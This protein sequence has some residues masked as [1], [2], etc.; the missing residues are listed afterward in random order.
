MVLEGEMNTKP[1]KLAS[2]VLILLVL[3]LSVVSVEARTFRKAVQQSDSELGAQISGAQGLRAAEP[4][5]SNL[6]PNTDSQT[7]NCEPT[8]KR[9]RGKRVVTQNCA[10][11]TTNRELQTANSI[12]GL[13][14]FSS[15]QIPTISQ[16]QN[17]IAQ[18]IIVLNTND[19]AKTKEAVDL[20]RKNGGVVSIVYIPNT[21]VVLKLPSNVESTLV[22]KYGAQISKS[23][24]P[25]GAAPALVNALN[26]PIETS[27]KTTQIREIR[28]KVLIPTDANANILVPPG[29]SGFPPGDIFGFNGASLTSGYMVGDVFVSVILPE[30]DGTI[31]PNLENWN[32]TEET[33]VDQQVTNALNWWVAR[34]TERGVSY[35][36]TFWTFPAHTKVNTG[37][38]PT[39]RVLSEHGLWVN[40]VFDKMGV[41]AA[42]DHIIRARNYDNSLRN[43]QLTDWAFTLFIPDASSGTNVEGSYAWLGGPYNVNN[44]GKSVNDINQNYLGETIT[45]ET[46]HIFWALD[47][48]LGS[49][50]SCTNKGGILQIENQNYEGGCLSNVPSIMRSTL[51]EYLSGALDPYGAGQIGWRDADSD[52]V[53]DSIDISYNTWDI[54]TDNDQTINYWDINDDN[55]DLN[56]VNDACPLSAGWSSAQG[57]SP[58]NLSVV[59][60]KSTAN[61]GEVVRVTATA[62][63]N[64]KATTISIY[65]DGANQSGTVCSRIGTPNANCYKDVSYGS[66]GAH[67]FYS[68]TTDDNNLTRD[69]LSGTKSFNIIDSGNPTV[70][71]SAA[72]TV[73]VNQNIR[74]TATATDNSQV[75]SIKIFIDGVDANGLTCSGIGTTSASCYKD[76]I[77]S[78]LGSHTFYSTATDSS[79]NTARDPVSGT[80]SFN[81]VDTTKP[82]VSVIG[83]ASPVP[84]SQ[85]ITI[86]GNANDNYQMSDITIYLDGTAVR[87][88]NG[89][90]T[91]CDFQTSFAAP[92][93][94]NYYATARDSSGNSAQT[95]TQSFEVKDIV[96][97][98]FTEPIIVNAAGSSVTIIAKAADNYQLSEIKIF[99]DGSLVKTCPVSGTSGQCDFTTSLNYGT[100][101]TYAV[102]TDSTGNTAAHPEKTFELKDNIKPNGVLSIGG[103]EPAVGKKFVVGI[104][105]S[106]D[107]QVSKIQ[108]FRGNSA[109]KTCN[110]NSKTATCEYKSNWGYESRNS[111]DYYAVVKDAAGNSVT[112]R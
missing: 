44:Y 26:A 6:K 90:A 69:P 46:G 94:H 19:V 79:S 83:P 78:T 84:I 27:S 102:A 58:V 8:I 45:H 110:A 12:T 1:V 32:A 16:S 96:A 41:P 93:T 75:S 106:D 35:P 37:Y 91:T 92:G 34:S 13:Q 36:L 17:P 24:I 89:G 40:D 85:T 55:D 99:L 30:S 67:T 15:S 65:I 61:V 43:N 98:T 33:I 52:S 64:F 18:T 25:N 81:V 101:R 31:D 70:S 71:V 48:Y 73:E 63:D 51:S 77:Y 97:P 57:C 76:L 29:S 7:T 105:A 21:L 72:A 4:Q 11:Q 56:D 54:D 87:T 80:K 49:G 39:Q 103:D 109:V 22:S 23:G 107:S 66:A 20:I 10:P 86:T 60:D 88:C 53:T 2:V 5:T 95:A 74:I 14:T 9:I 62:I 112:V 42:A 3:L 82:T 68:T 28:D 108:I 100:H 111:R 38:E 47:Q 59:S 104:S 50:E